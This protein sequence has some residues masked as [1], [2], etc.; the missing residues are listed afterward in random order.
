MDSQYNS[1]LINDPAKGNLP[2]LEHLI[3]AEHYL[4]DIID[5]NVSDHSSW[6]YEIKWLSL[7]V[8][9]PSI[10]SPK[11]IH[12]RFTSLISSRPFRLPILI[13]LFRHIKSM[14]RYP[15]YSYFIMIE[16]TLHQPY[17]QQISSKTLLTAI[18][19]RKA[20]FPP[21]RPK[22]NV[23]FHQCFS[24]HV[25]CTYTWYYLSIRWNI[26]GE[27]GNTGAVGQLIPAIVWVGGLMRTVWI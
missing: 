23:L 13:P 17:H 11:S 10:H 1:S 21:D 18:A 15:L 5:V 20:Q 26:V 12:K 8:F 27:L 7:K 19:F 25:C 16:T 9:L 2:S 6:C 4:Q 22:P 3:A 24:W 14:Y